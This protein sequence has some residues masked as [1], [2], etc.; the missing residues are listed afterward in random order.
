MN[1]MPVW[2]QNSTKLWEELP[3][4]VMDQAIKMHHATVRALLSTHNG[5]ESATEG[6]R[7]TSWL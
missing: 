1:C 7:C 2:L 3:G 4:A 5:Y 6:V